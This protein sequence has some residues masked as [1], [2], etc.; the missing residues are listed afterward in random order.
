MNQAGYGLILED[1]ALRSHGSVSIEIII[2]I[3]NTYLDNLKKTFMPLCK[4][5]FKSNIHLMVHL[6]IQMA[7]KCVYILL[8]VKDFSN[9]SVCLVMFVA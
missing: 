6:H 1:S 2:H 8:K 4:I 5:I 3:L 7:E 9:I